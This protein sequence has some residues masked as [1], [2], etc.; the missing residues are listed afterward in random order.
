MG[1][2]SG[3]CAGFVFQKVGKLAAA[4]I[5]GSFLFLQIASHSGYAQV[6]WKK[7]EK[8]I[9]KAKK[10]KR[11]QQIKKRAEKAAPEINDVIEEATELVQQ[12]VAI[13]SGFG[14]GF[15]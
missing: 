13:P 12:N 15:L 7:V 5:G 2:V 8:G 4:A 11:K 3:W 10:K 6:Y 14:G 9:N 1:G